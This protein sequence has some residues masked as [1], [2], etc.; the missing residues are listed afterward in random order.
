MKLSSRLKRNNDDKSNSFL[1]G[2]GCFFIAMSTALKLLTIK[3]PAHFRV[4]QSACQWMIPRLKTTTK[5]G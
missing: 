2:E 5:K 3:F 1:F 4:Q